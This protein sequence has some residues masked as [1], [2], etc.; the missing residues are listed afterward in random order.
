M[1]AIKSRTIEHGKNNGRLGLAT[2]NVW[3]WALLMAI[4]MHNFKGKLEPSYCRLVGII[5]ILE[6]KII[7]T[8]P[9]TVR[10]IDKKKVFKILFEILSH[11]IILVDISFEVKLS[12]NLSLELICDI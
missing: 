1:T 4:V 2:F 12:E 8:A 3:L 5:S 10:I 9:Q 7:S 11:Y 6:I